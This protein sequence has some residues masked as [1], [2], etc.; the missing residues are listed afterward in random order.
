MLVWGVVAMI[1]QLAIYALA[2]ITQPQ[3]ATAITEDRVSVAI[4]LAGVSLGVGVLNA[5]CM[6]F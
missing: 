4:V 3:L 6:T 1:V 5:A 2:R